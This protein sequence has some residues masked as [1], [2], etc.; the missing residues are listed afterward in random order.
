MRPPNVLLEDVL[1]AIDETISCLPETLDQFNADKFRRSHVLR[2]VQIIGEAA[3]R[4]PDDVKAKFAAVDWRK[5]AG[6]RHVLVHD[7]Y[8]VNWD[9]LYTTARDHIPSLRVHI[10]AM[11]AELN[12]ESRPM[13]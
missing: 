6:M 12:R 8:Q 10:V 2:Q 7:Y 13:D 5:I 1:A 3:W 4:L 11:L 9:I